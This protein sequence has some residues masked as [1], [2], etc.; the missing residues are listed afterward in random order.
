MWSEH[1]FGLLKG[2]GGSA[3][4]VWVGFGVEAKRNILFGMVCE[5]QDGS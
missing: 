5:E 1:C 2:E 3:G 4:I